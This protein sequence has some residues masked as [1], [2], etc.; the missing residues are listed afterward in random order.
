M[1]RFIV[2]FTMVSVIV[3][4]SL[5]FAKESNVHQGIAV[6]NESEVV[7][8]T[9]EGANIQK[10]AEPAANLSTAISEYQG[11]CVTKGS[12][13]TQVAQVCTPSGWCKLSG[14]PACC[15]GSCSASDRCPGGCECDY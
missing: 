7:T 6:P 1:K 4:A 5:S 3:W 14:S 2:F 13:S 9:T 8:F 12:S 15:S 11:Q 10:Q